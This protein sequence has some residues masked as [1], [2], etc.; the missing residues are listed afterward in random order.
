MGYLMNKSGIV[1]GYLMNKSG[2][3]WVI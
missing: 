3:V 2:I 1:L